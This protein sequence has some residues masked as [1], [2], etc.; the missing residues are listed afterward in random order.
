[1]LMYA[2]RRMLSI[3]AAAQNAPASPTGSRAFKCLRER[4]PHRYLS[5]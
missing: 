1:M 5:L 4:T 2:A 3:Y